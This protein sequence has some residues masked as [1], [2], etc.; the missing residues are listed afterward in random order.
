MYILVTRS[1]LQAKVALL[2]L[3]LLLLLL[4]LLLLVTRGT[5]QPKVA[6]HKVVTSAP[7]RV[8]AVK[9]DDDPLVVHLFPDSEMAPCIYM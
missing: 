9:E 5:L 2:L 6:L 3:P 8:G 4:Q 1:T 7:H